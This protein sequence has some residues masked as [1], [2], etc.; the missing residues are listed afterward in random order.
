[1]HQ[2][3]SA[4]YNAVNKQNTYDS[5]PPALFFSYTQPTINNSLR[6]G[7]NHFSHIARPRSTKMPRENVKNKH[8]LF[9]DNGVTNFIKPES[10]T[11]ET[12]VNLASKIC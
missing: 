9:T 5:L 11:G 7:N 8:L 10:Y 3:T 12:F 1:M 4:S 6:F 2:D